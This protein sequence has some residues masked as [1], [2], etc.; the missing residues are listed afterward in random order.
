MLSDCTTQLVQAYHDNKDRAGT[1]GGKLLFED[2]TIQ[3]AG[4]CI[5]SDGVP[6]HRGLTYAPS[7]YSETEN[8][9]GNTGAMLLI[10]QDLFKLVGGFREEFDHYFQ[11]VH[12]CMK[13][14]DEGKDNIYVGQAVAYHYEH[15]SHTNDDLKKLG[16]RCSKDLNGYLK[17]YISDRQDK[18]RDYTLTTP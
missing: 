15:K 18:F 6:T 14:I 8:V 16:E 10:S 12:L 2:G 1:V 5:R 7:R 9:L 13:C 11:D 17:E 4:Q 3:H